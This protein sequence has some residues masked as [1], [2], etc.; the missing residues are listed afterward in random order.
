MEQL[1]TCPN[2]SKQFPLSEVAAQQIEEAISERLVKERATLKKQLKKDYDTKF[3]VE[4]EKRKKLLE[5]DARAKAEE[6]HH[7][8]DQEKDGVINSLREQISNLERRAK[9]GSQQMQGEVAELSLESI[10][11]IN[12]P[13][14]QIEPVPQ[15]IRGA[16]ILQKVRSVTGQECGILV[17]ESK[18]T[19]TWND[20]WLSKLKDDQRDMRAE[21]AILV[22]T[23]LP[24]NITHFG[25][26][27]GVWV[28]D[29][30]YVV[31]LASVLREG[32][33]QIYSTRRA[34]EG[35]NEKM[36]MLYGYLA[37][38]DFKQKVEAIVEAFVNMNNDL[39]R[40][41]RAMET[42]WSKR[43]KQIQRVVRNIAGMYG[44]MQG[45]IGA[46]LPPIEHLELPT[47]YD[48]S[49]GE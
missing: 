41:K 13:S 6:E 39:E 11:R 26:M 18:N 16:D 29:A 25:N 46:T 22:S 31:G 12:F 32:M 33:I 5:D 28:T 4:F 19:K 24:A 40:E 47:P 49:E 30:R 1:I 3:K 36:E 14:D 43:E 17:W 23:V 45:I 48:T 34:T 15:G 8:K 10:L 44:D 7:R 38:T 2:C 42:A 27:E 37:G 21:I 9:Q 35:K 20:A